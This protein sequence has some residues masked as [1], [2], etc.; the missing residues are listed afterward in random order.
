MQK[1]NSIYQVSA[2][3]ILV[4]KPWRIADKIYGNFFHQLPGR[5][6]WKYAQNTFVM[7][8]LNR[9]DKLLLESKCINISCDRH[10][11]VP[12]HS[13][14]QSSC[15]L[16]KALVGYSYRLPKNNWASSFASR[17]FS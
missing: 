1:K 17:D 8:S 14:T 16:T 10:Y 4:E 3:H 13:N 12:M 2:V 7:F 5:Q 9:N 6:L 11:I 15:S